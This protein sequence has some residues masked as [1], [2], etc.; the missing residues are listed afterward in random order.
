AYSYTV[1]ARD[2]AGNVSA[3]STAVTATTATG[4]GGGDVQA[5]SVP[6]GLTATGTTTDT[7]S[8]AWTAS[9]DNTAVTGYDVYRG[10]V[11]VGSTTGATSYTD[12]GLT[13]ATAYS[14]TVKA[15]DA[16]GNVSAA[17]TAVTAT[18]ATGTG[19]AGCTAAWHIDNQWSTGFT[20]TVTVT[21]T[22]ATHAWKVAWTWPSG[23]TLSGSWNATV[24]QSGSSVTATSLAYNGTL[25]V[26]GTTTF[27]LQGTFTGSNTAPVF[28]CTAS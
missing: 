24:A 1:K 8:L 3:A 12:T 14:Y 28:T 20:S 19:G 15:R 2:A 5:P 27:G 18:T 23:Q 6:A 17:S 26:G 22:A 25:A 16:A 13:A 11:K 9:T 7:V 10:T 21:A 4:T